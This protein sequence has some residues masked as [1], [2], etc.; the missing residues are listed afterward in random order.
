MGCRSPLLLGRVAGEAR[1]ERLTRSA[2]RA[3]TTGRGSLAG[4]P[5][6]SRRLKKP[7]VPGTRPWGNQAS[8]VRV[9]AEERPRRH[10]ASPARAPL[11]GA[12][13]CPRRS[14]CLRP[15]SWSHALKTVSFPASRSDDVDRP[16]LID[17]I[18]DEVASSAA[19]PRDMERAETWVNLVARTTVGDK[20]TRRQGHEYITV[21]L[22]RPEHP[23]FSRSSGASTK[24][25]IS[26]SES[27]K[28]RCKSA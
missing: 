15:S 9:A 19:L 14:V 18:D 12:S 24:P 23:T 3:R 20:W 16:S 2:A 10:L 21:H 5:D 25:S 1:H 22:A 13:W 27:V 6:G 28:P 17:A 11:Q 4:Q 8:G 26:S 7:T